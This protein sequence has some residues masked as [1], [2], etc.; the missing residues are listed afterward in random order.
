MNKTTTKNTEPKK[1]IISANGVAFRLQQPQK[2]IG[3]F[4]QVKPGIWEAIQE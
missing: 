2:K 4:K 3:N 1:P